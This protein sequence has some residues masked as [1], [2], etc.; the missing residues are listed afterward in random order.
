MHANRQVNYEP[1]RNLVFVIDVIRD[2]VVGGE[3]RSRVDHSLTLSECGARVLAG[4]SV[5]PLSDNLSMSV[6]GECLTSGASG[7]NAQVR[8][9]AVL[10]QEGPIPHA[11]DCVNTYNLAAIVHSTCRRR[12]HARR[13]LQNRQ[14]TASRPEKRVIQDRDL[15][16]HVEAADKA[17][18]AHAARL[19]RRRRQP[20]TGMGAAAAESQP[21]SDRESAPQRTAPRTAATRPQPQ[22]PTN[23]GMPI[24]DSCPTLT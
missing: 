19:R 23:A 8:P 15:A 3:H 20:A 10:P 12:A 13:P 21:H 9:H 17:G 4:D 7:E 22:L 5:V 24:P 11:G 16:L 6:D 18:F 14:R 1:A 2:A